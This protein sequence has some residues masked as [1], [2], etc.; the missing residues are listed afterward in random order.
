[1]RFIITHNEPLNETVFHMR[2]TGDTR[3]I[4]RPGQFVQLAVPGRFLR[5]P[6]SVCDWEAGERG[7]LDLIYKVVGGGTRDMSAMRPGEAADVLPGLGNGYD[8]ACGERPALVGGGVGAPPLYGLAKRMLA[9]GKA[10]R[11][12]LGF[13][14]AGEAF[15]LD[16]FHAL[17]AEV[18]VSTADGSLG[19]KGLVTDALRGQAHDF[20]YVCGPK[21]MLRAV[22]ALGIPGQYSF[23]ERMACGFGAC[24]GCSIQTA[25]GPRRVCK[26]GPV[27][28]GEEIVW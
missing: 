1:M 23:E 14:T 28:K 17:G 11:V 25:C 2:L 19:V 3:A 15:W 9:A 5:R 16:R 22:H 8:P 7:T 10:P 24:M 18:V 13:N 6:I 20:L 12:Y 21:P 4:V 27:F 26:D